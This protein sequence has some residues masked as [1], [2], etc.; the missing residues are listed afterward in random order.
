[1]TTNPQV[2]ALQSQLSQTRETLGRV[3]DSIA[4]LTER[5]DRLEARLSVVEVER[6][7]LAERVGKLEQQ[8]ARAMRL[9]EREVRASFGDVMVDE[10]TQPEVVP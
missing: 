8:Q 7:H 6:D 1:M 5:M 9:H 10:V 4:F 2:W 3:L